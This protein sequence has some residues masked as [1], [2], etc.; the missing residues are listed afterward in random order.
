[1][2]DN[3]STHLSVFEL[4]EDNFITWH[5]CIQAH[6][7]QRSLLC[8]VH[9]N[10]LPPTAPTLLT[11]QG[12]ATVLSNTESITNAQAE[13]EYKRRLKSWF[14][15]DK[16]ARGTILAHVSTTQR[17]HIEGETSAYAMWQAL[18]KIHMQQVPGTCFST[19]N[20]LF[21]IVKRPED[22]LTAVAV[23]HVCHGQLQA[24]CGASRACV[25]SASI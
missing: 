6:L 22:T 20:E 5:P 18:L 2:S 10:L 8:V 25:I 24:S 14:D 1:M 21:L 7:A 19:Y 4:T 16:K 11:P 17:V 9:D 13:Q 15:K 23:G 12:T 3:T